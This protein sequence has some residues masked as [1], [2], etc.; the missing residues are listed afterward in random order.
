[1]I[2]QAILRCRAGALRAGA[3]QKEVEGLGD[4]AALAHGKVDSLRWKYDL[5]YRYHILI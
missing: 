5:L 4:S 3:T 2:V 1:M